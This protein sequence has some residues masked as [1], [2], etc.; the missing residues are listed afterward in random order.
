M[1]GCRG[2]SEKGGAG[3]ALSLG[4]PAPAIGQDHPIQPRT[5]LTSRWP[6]EDGVGG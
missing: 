1:A 3:H 6:Q 4:V 5:R 2:R